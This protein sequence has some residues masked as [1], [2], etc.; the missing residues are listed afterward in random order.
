MDMAL[1]S[2][3]SLSADNACRPALTMSLFVAMWPALAAL[4]LSSS[5]RALS[6]GGIENVSRT[7]RDAVCTEI[8]GLD[9]SGFINMESALSKRSCTN[10]SCSSMLER[11]LVSSD[12]LVMLALPAWLIFRQSEHLLQRRPAYL[13]CRGS[14]PP[15]PQLSLLGKQHG[16]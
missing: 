2:S 6:S 16:C 15:V 4:V 12:F 10:R 13:L 5:I 8:E 1:T 14:R 9:G 3:C 7:T 11:S